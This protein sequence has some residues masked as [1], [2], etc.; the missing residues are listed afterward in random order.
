MIPENN[1]I[2]SGIKLLKSM[3]FKKSELNNP[4][5]FLSSFILLCLLTVGEPQS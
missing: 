2:I 4:G 3:F 1:K 5:D